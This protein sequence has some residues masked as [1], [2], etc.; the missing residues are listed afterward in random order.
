MSYNITCN[1]SLLGSFRQSIQDAVRDSEESQ[2]AFE[3]ASRN[4]DAAKADDGDLTPEQLF[5]RCEKARR[6]KFLKRTERDRA[7]KVPDRLEKEFRVFLE[8]D[9]VKII[10]ALEGR[11]AGIKAR[12]KKKLL[13]LTGG[14]D[15]A[16][17]KLVQFVDSCPEH[18]P[19]IMAF[20]YL[21][22]CRDEPERYASD[23]MRLARGVE[24]AIK[25]LNAES[26]AVQPG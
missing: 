5:E 1:L 6:E 20:D 23:V 16:I 25:L 4:L 10:G 13:P 2:S 12:I 15:F 22:K 21:S 9:L 19:Y 26:D 3:E 7:S 17:A 24:D 11:A 18:R 8:T 14:E